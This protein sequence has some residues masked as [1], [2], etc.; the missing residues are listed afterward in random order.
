MKTMVAVI[1]VLLLGHMH[2]LVSTLAGT[3][4]DDFSEAA[5]GHEWTGNTNS[6]SI[7][8][9]MLKGASI[10]PLAPAPFNLIEVGKGWSNYVVQCMINVVTPNLA[11][12]TKGALVL[13]HNGNEG[14]VFALHQATQTI[15][16]Y[17]LSTEQMLLSKPADLKLGQWYKVRAELK[18]E[19]MTF[20]VDDQL[21]GTV[22]DTKALSGSVGLA[23]QDTAETDFDSFS[24]TG[25]N[26]PSNGLEAFVAGNQIVLTWPNSLTNYG[27][28]ATPEITPTP[29]WTGVTN[30]PVNGGG[31]FSLTLD[32]GPDTRFYR[33]DPRAQTNSF[34]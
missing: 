11:V 22:T 3:W 33:L 26:I 2:P 18:G 29:I 10:S 23:V 28:V 7:E 15:E 17:R 34:R 4:S 21:G 6:F 32:L 14:Y 19:N 8:N 12:C 1:F 5:L 20:F 25:P 27:L 9:G 30:Q 31:Y 16:V 24:V 13:R